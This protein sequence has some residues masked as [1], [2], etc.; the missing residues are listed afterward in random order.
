MVTP[1]P[2]PTPEPA[3]EPATAAPE[4]AF[5]VAAEARPPRTERPP[6]AAS[7]PAPTGSAAFIRPIVPIAPPPRAPREEAPTGFHSAVVPEQLPADALPVGMVPLSKPATRASRPPAPDPP[8]AAAPVA[9][10]PA[11]R[12]SGPPPTD[13]GP[14]E[15]EIVPL[16]IPDPDDPGAEDGAPESD[17]PPGGEPDYAYPEETE[18]PDA[19]A[20]PQ[21]ALPT[22]EAPLPGQHWFDDDTPRRPPLVFFAAGGA[23]IV[24]ITVIVVILMFGGKESKGGEAG[25]DRPGSGAA[26]LASPQPLPTGAVGARPVPAEQL[27][28]LRPQAVVVAVFEGQLKVSWDPPV[29]AQQVSG[30]FV[31]TQ[32]REGRV[33]ERRLVEPG[34]GL[35]EV[36]DGGDLCAVVTTVVSTNEGLQLARGELVCPAADTKTP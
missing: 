14:D 11:P 5:P 18:E 17:V 24:L 9:T 15:W 1:E 12:R 6:T 36:F 10:G 21:W 3:R 16:A 25:G 27:P 28:G 34:S 31:V 2:E 8:V 35:S 19:P 33:E 7:T 13:F 20:T 22:E 30:Y 4:P 23:L 29:S 32:T 26:S